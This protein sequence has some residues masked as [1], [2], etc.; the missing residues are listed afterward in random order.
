MFFDEYKARKKKHYLF[1]IEIFCDI[2]HFFTVTFNQ[3]FFF[4][5][6]I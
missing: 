2:I 6:F 4:L 3:I 5:T 1:E